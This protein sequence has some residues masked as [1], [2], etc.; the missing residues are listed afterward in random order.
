MGHLRPQLAVQSWLLASPE[1]RGGRKLDWCGWH[2]QA[3]HA[4]G[5]SPWP[6]LGEVRDL[7]CHQKGLTASTGHVIIWGTL[8]WTNIPHKVGQGLAGSTQITHTRSK[9]KLERGRH[10][11][12]TRCVKHQSHGPL[13]GRRHFYFSPLPL[14][15]KDA[16][17]Q[18]AAQPALPCPGCSAPG[19]E[20]V[21]EGMYAGGHRRPVHRSSCC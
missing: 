5:S 19:T 1:P 16:R 20:C 21:L 3:T 4:L 7:K 18:A 14:C 2:C 8:D 11:P 13:E 17:S 15:D 6:I 12:A 10:E 9:T